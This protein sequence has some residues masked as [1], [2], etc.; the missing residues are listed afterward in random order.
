MGWTIKVSVGGTLAKLKGTSTF[1]GT[2]ALRV[3][4]CVF[5]GIVARTGGGQ[6]GG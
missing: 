5:T 4:G 6:E 1:S 2:G 3:V